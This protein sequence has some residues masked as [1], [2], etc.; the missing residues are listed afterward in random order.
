MAYKM[1]PFGF[2]LLVTL[3]VFSSK[4][5]I[6][7]IFYGFIFSWIPSYFLDFLS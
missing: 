6:L 4:Q 1:G 3:T 5:E 2:I 7:L